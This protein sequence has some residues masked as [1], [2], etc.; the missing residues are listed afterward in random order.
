[1]LAYPAPFVRAKRDDSKVLGHD[2]LGNLYRSLDEDAV[3]SDVV[4]LL[5]L[6]VRD[7]LGVA[8]A[9][10][11]LVQRVAAAA[12]LLEVLPVGV[13][14]E[15]LGDVLGFGQRRVALVQDGESHLV[16]EGPL[17][18]VVVLAGQHADVDGEVGALAAAVAVEEGRH[19]Q[20]VA[21]A[22]GVEW[23]AE[24]LVVAP[25]L[26]LL[27]LAGVVAELPDQDAVVA[28]G[29]LLHLPPQLK[30]LL[31]LAPHQVAHHG[32]V[33]LGGVLQVTANSQFGALRERG[34]DLIQWTVQID[35]HVMKNQ[36]QDELIWG[37]FLNFYISNK[38]YRF[39][40]HLSCIILLDNN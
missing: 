14:V 2:L 25:Q 27:Q 5:D 37:I 26:G 34:Y 16:G 32:Q 8:K 17:Q 29:Q 30:D 23:R 33:G 31:P 10:G 22:V 36:V 9:Q 35:L 1:M 38:K 21:V 6:L 13:G 19:L 24:E 39:V 28:D 12:G 18:Q 40:S 20:L 3:V 7:E 15:G 4:P 11:A